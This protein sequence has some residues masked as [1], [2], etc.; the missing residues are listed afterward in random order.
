MAARQRYIFQRAGRYRMPKDG[1]IIDELLSALKRYLD[2][3]GDTEQ[4][5]ALKIGV[6]HRTLNRWL[7]GSLKERRRAWLLRRAFSSRRG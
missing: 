1:V 5:V 6:N 4:A 2:E 3:S 7:R